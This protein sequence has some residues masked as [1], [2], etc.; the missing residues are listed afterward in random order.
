MAIGPYMDWKDF[1]IKKGDRVGFRRGDD[2][3]VVMTVK[4]VV[5]DEV[6]GEIRITCE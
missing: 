1:D 5:E 3:A 2:E 6:T 4:E